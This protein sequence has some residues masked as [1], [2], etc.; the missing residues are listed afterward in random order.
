MGNCYCNQTLNTIVIDSGGF[1][2]G[3]AWAV[4]VTTKNM[5]E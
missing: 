1:V 2:G 5:N 3:G 4:R